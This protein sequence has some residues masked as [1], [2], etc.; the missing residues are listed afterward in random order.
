MATP[1]MHHTGGAGTGVEG[2]TQESR[3]F[4]EQRLRDD[5][6]IWPMLEY[7]HC[8]VVLGG[9]PGV[10]CVFNTSAM[11]AARVAVGWLSTD[12]PRPH[13]PLH[14]PQPQQRPGG[15]LVPP[16]RQQQVAQPAQAW[17]ALGNPQQQQQPVQRQLWPFV[18]Q[19]VAHPPPVKV[20]W[21]KWAWDR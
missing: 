12:G 18:Q 2:Q 15:L 10:G 1:S 13:P 9:E 7:G 21:D 11:A 14:D 6:I 3:Q 8:L 16:H 17:D 20:T 19:Q 4:L 5:P